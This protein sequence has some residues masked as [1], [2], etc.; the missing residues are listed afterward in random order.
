MSPPRF[1]FLGCP[2]TVWIGFMLGIFITIGQARPSAAVGNLRLGPVELH[3]YFQ[4]SESFDDN[5]CRTKE[6]ECPD[7]EDATETQDGGDLITVFTPGLQAVLPF[8]VHRLQVDYQ[9]NFGRYAEFTTENYS[10]NQLKGLLTLDFPGGLSIHLKDDWKNGH[11][12][13]AFNQNAEID[14]YRQNAAGADLGIKFGPKLHL[15]VN[16][17]QL[18]LNYEE[19]RNDFRDRTDSTI[20]GAIYFKF[21]PKTFAL[22]EYNNADVKFEE[23][24]PALGD[25]NSTV[26]RTYLGLTWAITAR[27]HGTLKGGYVR[28]D[29]EEADT[30]YHGGIV[31]AL[32]EH[33]FSSRNSVRLAAIRDVRE[34]NLLTQTH[35]ISTSSSL[36]WTHQIHARLSAALRAGFGRDRY[37][38]EDTPGGDDRIDKTWEGG[39]GLEYRL[40]DWLNAGLRYHRTQRTSTLDGF[41]FMDNLYTA[42]VKI[43]L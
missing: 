39:V 16:Y 30:D 22:A 25:L 34:S 18:I 27:S 32:L 13:R 38:E 31:S 37:P 24:N 26:H 28:K 43:I 11:D 29:F 6:E 40:P 23:D 17:T 35:Y 8:D 36:E 1:F 20:G 3:P 9:A 2:V 12:P 14:F 33:E 4:I 19:D 21:L 5:V 41:E 7:P 15:A 10:D 42:S